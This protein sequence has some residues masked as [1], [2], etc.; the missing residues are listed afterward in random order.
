MLLA[1]AIFFF[2]KD[3]DSVGVF[4]AGTVLGTNVV[5]RLCGKFPIQKR[6]GASPK[7][8]LR[9]HEN[10]VLA[11]LVIFM[12]AWGLIV[13][14]DLFHARAFVDWLNSWSLNGW[15]QLAMR[16]IHWLFPLA[17]VVFVPVLRTAFY[18]ERRV[19]LQVTWALL[20]SGIAALL[21]HLLNRTV[22]L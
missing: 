12:V 18:L 6:A 19:W 1:L 16:P 21:L 15:V 10:V 11:G 7:E 9:G 17:W 4:I 22:L 5:D 13:Y 2:R 8:L 14:L 20:A 3:G